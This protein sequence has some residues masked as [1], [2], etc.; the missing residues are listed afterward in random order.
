[1]MQAKPAAALA[2]DLL[3]RKG[4]AVPTSLVVLPIVPRAPAGEFKPELSVP[5]DGARGGKP[6]RGGAA[7]VAA[8]LSLRLDGDRHHRLRLAALHL[9]RSGQQILVEALD[10]YLERSAEVILDGQC[11]CL[12]RNSP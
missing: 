9:G 5:R 7:T 2:S 1:M 12:R 10:V 11:A 3:A 8:K 4:E 6:P